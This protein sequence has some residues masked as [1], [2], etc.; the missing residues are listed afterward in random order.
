MVRDQVM[1][2]K[3]PSKRA[4]KWMGQQPVQQQRAVNSRQR[5]PHGPLEALLDRFLK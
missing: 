1:D 3:N 4:V 5:N 2:I